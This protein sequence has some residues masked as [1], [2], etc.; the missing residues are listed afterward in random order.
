MLEVRYKTLFHGIFRLLTFQQLAVR[1][2]LCG[3]EY[4]PGTVPGFKKDKN[5]IVPI[6]GHVER[7]EDVW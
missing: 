6:G 4:I 7:C 1:V 5:C 3:Q 2:E